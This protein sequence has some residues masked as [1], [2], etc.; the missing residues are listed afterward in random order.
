MVLDESVSTAVR[1]RVTRPAPK[2]GAIAAAMPYIL[3]PTD[4]PDRQRMGGKGAALATLNAHFAIPPWFVIT[5]AALRASLTAAEWQAL[6]QGEPPQEWHLAPAVAT[7]LAD[8]L[9]ALDANP[10]ARFAVR[11]SATGEDG[12]HASFAGQLASFLQ[13]SRTELV[14][15]IFAVWQ[16]A[17]AEHVHHYRRQMAATTAEMTKN[18]HADLWVPAVIVQRMVAADV[19]GVAFGADPVSGARSRCTITAVRGL[20]DQLVSGAVN[21]DTYLTD[22]LGTVLEQRTV[23]SMPLLDP[24]TVRAIATLSREVEAQ[25]GIPQDIEW[26]LADGKLWLLQARPITTLVKQAAQEEPRE[27]GNSPIKPGDETIWDNSNIVESYSGVT[28]PLTFSFARHVYEQVYREFCKLMGV[29]PDKI[30]REEEAFRNLLGYINGH[31]YYNLLNWYR[32]LALFP[33]FQMNRRFMEQMMGVKEPLA[34]EWLD[35]VAPPQTSRWARLVD[36]WRLARAGWGLLWG[37]LTMA[38]TMQRFQRRL[39]EA[40]TLTPDDMVCMSLPRLAAEY[41]LVERQLL[42][43][44][45]APLINDFLC[46]I[47]FG[48]SRKLLAQQAGV[49]GLALHSTLLIGQGDIIS[50]EPAQRI[51]AMAALIV[52][53]DTLVDTLSNRPLDEAL[54][55]LTTLP[56]LQAAYDDYLAKFGNRCLQE[57]KLESATL[58]DD[59]TTL[60]RAI[61]QMALRLRTQPAEQVGAQEATAG[62]G[63]QLAPFFKGQPLRHRFMRGI[64]GWAKRRVQARENLRFERTR[65]FGYARQLFL[66]MGTRLVEAGLL[67]EHRDIFLLTVDE[68]LAVVDGTAT[69]A[70]LSALAALRKGER[71]RFN[72]LPAPPNRFISNGAR[73]DAVDRLYTDT[74]QGS[75]HTDERQGI[76]CCAGVVRAPVRVIKEPRGATLQPGEIMV[77]Q[78]TDPG[79]I[80]LFANA[81]GILVE[82]GSLLSHSAIVARE[83]GIPAIVAIDGVTAWLQT[84]DIVEMDG[85]TGRV[86]KVQE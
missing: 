50:A 25:V 69:T 34:D 21:G 1:Q 19:A 32:I 7:A 24:T 66:A 38:R 6:T 86:C 20:A 81:S 41:R 30:A 12:G 15:R 67:Q 83:L 14:T 55:A 58:H 63:E 70:D 44:W 45:D 62:I 64:M 2:P 28:S 8:A 59:P 78:F 18:V 76:G 40:L 84:G 73:C 33:G 57:L 80:T 72:R 11:S 37:E 53:D 29:A 82:R 13:V 5:P 85:I 36:G 3:W 68:V 35:H 48:L 46:M 75:K 22:R 39:D 31:V 52:D 27:H 4:Q 23:A 77:A 10:Q 43:Q 74:G 79:W 51:R 56:T 16:S 47:A 54:A 60:V 61:G 71:A 9:I 65:V 26:A 17:F 49:A 42:T